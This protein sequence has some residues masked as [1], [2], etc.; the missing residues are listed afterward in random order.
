MHKLFLITLLGSFL[1]ALQ[2]CLG[3]QAKLPNIVLI[4]ADDMG[5]ADIGA[6]GSEINTPNLDKMAENGIRFTQFYNGARCCPS[7]ASLLTGLYA[8][9]AGVGQMVYRN[10][11]PGYLGYINEQSVTLAEVLKSTGYNTLMAGKWHVGHKKGQRPRDRGFDRFYGIHKHVDSYYKALKGC[12][13]YLDDSMLIT[14]NETPVNHLNPEQE[15]YTTDAFTDYAIEFIKEE[16]DDDKPF[17]LYLAYNAP[18]FPLEAPMEDI[19]KYQGTY[20]EGWDERRK[21]KLE[22]MKQMGIL[23]PETKLSPSENAIWDTLSMEDKKELDFRRAIYA[24]Q[25]DRMDQN[26]GRLIKHLEESGELDNTLIMF[27]SDNGSSAESGSAKTMYGMNWPEYKMAN[28]EEWRKKGGWSVSQ[29]RAWANLSN[30]PFRLY[31][32]WTH[33]GGISTPFIAYWP[34]VIKQKGAITD[35]LGHIIDIMPTLCEVTG[36][37]YPNSYKGNSIQP[38]EGRSLL[39]LFK[40]EPA[41]EHQAVFWSHMGNNAVRMGKWK[42][43]LEH[44][45]ENWELYDMS[46]DRT[47]LNDLASQHPDIVEKLKTQYTAWAKRSNVRSWPLEEN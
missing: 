35:Q 28:F 37:I 42:L 38:Q 43:V 19:Q 34:E 4:F 9:Q 3:Q 33:E 22:R 47:E 6:F 23:P 11:G 29:G 40:G 44:G 41:E 5:Y 14:A 30:T 7:R 36:A 12:E 13:V 32:R 46:V 1:F 17:F 15:W 16:S 26:I 31:K 20:M 25:I 27:L 2:P 39:P 24:A 8:H 18:H 10:D 45:R 21:Q